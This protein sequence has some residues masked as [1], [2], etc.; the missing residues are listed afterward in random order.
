MGD[1]AA[2]RSAA[3]VAPP[4]DV[5]WTLGAWIVRA[6]GAWVLAG[7]V[8]KA[9]S[10]TPA[11][12]PAPVLALDFDPI[13]IIVL[14]AVVETVVAIVALILP[15]LGAIP[16]AALL[17]LFVTILVLHLRSGAESCGCF[18]GALPIPAW[19]VLVVDGTLLLGILAT[20]AWRGAMPRAA[21]RPGLAG[22][23]A[24]ICGLA[25]GWMADHRLAALRPAEARNEGGADART[26]SRAQ[27]AVA[28]SPHVGSQPTTPSVAQSGA[29][30]PPPP[31]APAPWRLPETIPDQVLLRPT[32][33]I[34]RRLAET[35]LGRWT[36]TSAF[37]SDA[38]LVIYYLS[39]N[40]CAD[41]LREL[42]E[43]QAADP[44]S[45]P[46]YVLVQLPTPSGY[47]GRLFVDRVP[48]GLRVELPAAVKT[49]V[50]TP[51]WD[52]TLR[53]GVVAGAERIKWSG[54]K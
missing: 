28:A 44:A 26:A 30:S 29:S 47:K 53:G 12:L 4:A 27:P 9:F 32:Q 8:A 54:E 48:E 49:W 43:Q 5:A 38:T 11:E 10:S 37:P 23:A 34:G 51:P 35:E 20:R 21:G 41:H 17:G 31:A 14:A 36:D 22:A 42:A 25:L 15:R 39:C 40:H 46:R 7:A 2:Q 52:V 19:L 45:S 3:T 13:A 6:A 18:G 50:I 24:L 1:T 33:W 16:M